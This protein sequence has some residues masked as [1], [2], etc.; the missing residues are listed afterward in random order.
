MN[1]HRNTAGPGPRTGTSTPR[2]PRCRGT[3]GSDRSRSSHCNTPDPDLRIGRS[4][5]RSHSD[6]N[7][8]RHRSRNRARSRCHKADN[9]PGNKSRGFPSCC[10]ARYNLCHPPRSS[11]R[12][13][14][15]PVGTTDSRRDRS[16][17]PSTMSPRCS[18]RGRMPQNSK[19]IPGCYRTRRRRSPLD[20]SSGRFAVGTCLRGDSRRTECTKRECRSCRRPRRR[21][22]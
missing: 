19:P 17:L 15:S 3:R 1:F 8:E 18:S 6:S 20:W 11:T 12:S 4:R 7:R 5:R 14:S 9:F 13:C 2:P 10:W 16:R 21:C 22:H